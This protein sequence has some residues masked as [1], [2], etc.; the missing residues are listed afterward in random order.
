MAVGVEQSH[1]TLL[2]RAVAPRRRRGRAPGSWLRGMAWFLALLYLASAAAIAALMPQTR[3]ASHDA[4]FGQM[5]IA[6]S[7]TTGSLS[8]IDPSVADAFFGGANSFALGG[9]GASTTAKAWASEEAFEEDL[10]AGRISSSVRAVMYDP[11]AWDATPL[12]ERL[13]PVAAMRRFATL[14][15]ANG[16]EVVL[17]PHPNL[18]GVPGGEC[19][20]GPDETQDVAF[21][22]C[23]L[24]TAAARDADVVEV[25]AQ[26]LETDPAAYERFVSIAA[27]RARAAH[28]GVLV[29]SGL[30]TN[31]TTDPAVLF[32]AWLAVRG[33]VDGHYL[34]V[35][36]G[37]RWNVA[38]AFLRLVIA[39]ARLNAS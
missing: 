33:A 15:R 16:F 28:P 7:R 36:S 11:E 35:P 34:N 29:L 30:S 32:R 12:D 25:Q 24:L 39:A 3:A 5:W 9:F 19:T 21:L 8:N 4:P 37:D 31:F 6:T 27:A 23:G 2:R 26:W 14:A 10:A 17:T 18:V 20:A 13:R 1:R 22:R 38:V